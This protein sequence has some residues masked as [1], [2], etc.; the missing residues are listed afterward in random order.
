LYVTD[1]NYSRH[2][3]RQCPACLLERIIGYLYSKTIGLHRL[4]VW[5]QDAVEEHASGDE[6]SP[7]EE[8]HHGADDIA[9]DDAGQPYLG[10]FAVQSRQGIDF[11]EVCQNSE[12]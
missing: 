8:Q 6:P 9:E 5:I 3:K 1:G 12:R 10:P 7:A 11:E 4:I 2:G